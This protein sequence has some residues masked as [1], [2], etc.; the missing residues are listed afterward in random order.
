MIYLLIALSYHI[1]GTCDI[2]ISV[3]GF[4]ADQRQKQLFQANVQSSQ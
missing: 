4:Y 2:Y 1:C 3:S